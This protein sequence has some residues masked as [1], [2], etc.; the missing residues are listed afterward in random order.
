MATMTNKQKRQW[1]QSLYT[2]E[3]RTQAEVAAIVEVSRQTIVRWSKE[4]R[5]D[6]LKAGMTMTREEQIKNLQRQIVEIN[7]AI[8]GRDEGQR[9]A[10]PKEAD[11]IN[12]IATAINKLETDAGIHE[13]VSAG[14]RFIAFLR[15]VNLVKAQEF[16][17]LYNEFIKSLL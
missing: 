2:N 7:N 15:P 9:F 6:E 11:T 8:R 1:A 14:Q 3:N 17:I 16:T 4:D 13:L 12:K 5:W 10:S